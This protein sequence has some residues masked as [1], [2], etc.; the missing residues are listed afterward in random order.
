MPKVKITTPLVCVELEAN[1]A[2]VEALG[3]Q[4]VALL[5]EAATVLPGRNEVGFGGQHAERRWTQDHHDTKYGQGGF[6]PVQARS[7]A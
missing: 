4:A 5:G 6:G 7:E 3:K 1:E 2:S